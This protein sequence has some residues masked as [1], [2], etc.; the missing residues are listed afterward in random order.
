MSEVLV[1]ALK[2]GFLA[3]LWLFILLAANVIRTDLFGRT[4]AAAQL[5]T[6]QRL[7]EASRSRSRGSRKAPRKLTV[8][9][10]PLK[11]T[12]FDLT[13]E[14]KVGRSVDCQLILDDDYVSTRHARIY[15]DGTQVV[16]EDLGSTNGT[17]VNGSRIT[18]PTAVTA[19]DTVRIGRTHLGLG[20]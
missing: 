16:V 14:V 5:P 11:G 1:A 10:G 15:S 13:S 2:I 18:V 6:A 4:V 12:T 9:N 3:V 19:A 20:K 7:N 17:Y 8:N